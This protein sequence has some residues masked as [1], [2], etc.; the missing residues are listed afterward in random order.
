MKVLLLLFISFTLS[1]I[2]R[3]QDRV[4][5][6]SERSLYSK[7]YVLNDGTKEE[8][9]SI[10]PVHYENNGAWLPINTDL[11][12][13]N[14]QFVNS[15]N[16]IK[17]AF[18]TVLNSESKVELD[19][20]GNKISIEALKHIVTYTDLG[21]VEQLNLPFNQ[22]N[23]I[24]TNN[25]LKYDNVYNG[26][27]DNFTVL[28]GEIK[29]DFTINDLPQELANITEGY[30]GFQERFVL[31]LNWSLEPMTVQNTELIHSGIKILDDNNEH[32]LTIPAP[33]FFDDLGMSNDGGSMVEG[34]FIINKDARG[35]LLS[36]VAP[37]NWLK[38][39]SVIYPVVMDPSVVLAGA[40]GGWQSQNNFVNNP[41]FVFI[42]VCCGNLEH[43]AWVQF[44]T[45][46]IDDASC[47]QSV[48]FEAFVNG[49]GGAASELVHAFD[50][51][52]AF[53]PYGSIMP[54]VYTDMGN[55]YYTSF[56]IAGTGTYG[57]YDLGPSAS[58]LLQ[59]QLTTMNG[60]QVSLIFDNEPSTNWKR[61]T[62]GLCN[63]RVTYDP[64]PCAP[65]PVGLVNFETKCE[66]DHAQ[67]TWSTVTES[68]SD[69]FTVW[70]SK[71]G[72][73]Y[74]EVA[75]VQA[76]EN[77]TA[78]LNYR[79]AD[80]SEVNEMAYYKL[81]QTDLDGSIQDFDA[82]IYTGCEDSNPVVFIDDVNDIRIRGNNITEVVIRDNMGRTI[83]TE[84]NNGDQNELTISNKGFITGM[85]S[86][87]ITYDNGKQKSMKFLF[88][89]E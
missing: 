37:V 60:F 61:L 57:Y 58:A 66:N 71:D 43:R 76:N 41:G 69:Y 55:G 89:E 4:E 77:S 38:D 56:S 65:L 53:G 74:E 72:Q 73:E 81:T 19:Y 79:W 17:S 14:K 40:T 87:T 18:P 68:N 26:Y 49:V 67:L 27:N 86:A 62:A 28:N 82:K 36:T 50:M 45:T 63:L 22:S 25:K 6:P 2:S 12:S 59:T 78:I 5:I 33:I 7:M 16:I 54:A 52:G 20:N 84:L 9:I 32:V 47:V 75:Q 24:V 80:L 46:S 10:N 15:E 48:E 35:W 51:T 8:I 29:N 1:P 70:K 42:G 3:A 13:S 21:G 44:N 31:P 30:F 85:Y 11:T 39:P 83:A 34:A 64:P 88:S 23:A